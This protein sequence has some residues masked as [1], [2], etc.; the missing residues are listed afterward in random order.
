MTTYGANTGFAQPGHRMGNTSYK[1]IEVDVAATAGTV[2][3]QAP[4]KGKLARG[5]MSAGVAHNATN[6]YSSIALVNKS[7]SD[8]AMLGTN[9][10]GDG[11]NTAQYGKRVLVLHGTAANLNV[12][13]GDWL[14]LTTTVQGTLGAASKIQLVFEVTE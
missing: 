14:E 9:D 1:Y 6:N 10:T 7:N 11:T 5:F 4:T 8:A 12:S 13:E 3:I 2:V